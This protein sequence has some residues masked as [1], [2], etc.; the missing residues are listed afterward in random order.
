M[1]Q[2]K[3]TR[4][5][6]LVPSQT[7]LLYDLGLRDEVIGITKFCIHPDEWFRRKQRVGGTKN[8]KIDLIKSLNPDLILANKEEN[9][10]EEIE[11][12][13]NDFNVYVSDISTINEAL[14]MI[15]DIGKLVH[16]QQKSIEIV[17]GI[18]AEMMTQ[19]RLEKKDKIDAL[20]LIWQNPYMVAGNDTFIHDMMLEA[21]FN[22]LVKQNRYPMMTLEEIKSINPTV[23]MLSSEPFP[24]ADKHIIEWQMQLPNTKIILV[25]GELFSWYGSRML[26]SFQYFRGLY[27]ELSS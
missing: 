26:K 3:P 6:S 4:I 12:L 14:Q 20:Y 11:I 25:D 5:I 19:S 15:E 23:I 27:E 2:N 10:K 22:N 1:S 17:N 13:Q 7:E 16:C 9:L 21:G 18:K 24:F 8:L